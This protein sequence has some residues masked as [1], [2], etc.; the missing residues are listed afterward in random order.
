MPRLQQREAQWTYR[1]GIWDLGSMIF[2]GMALFKFG[3]FTG[4]FSRRK[5]LM[6]GLAGITIGLLLGWFRLHYQQYSLFDYGKYIS[7]HWLP[8]NIFFPFER[9]FM[10]LGYI[11]LVMFFLHAAVLKLVWRGFSNVGQLAL[12]NYLMQSIICA[13]FFTGVGMGY[14][15]RLNQ[16]QLYFFAAEICIVQIIFS[17]LWLRVFYIG[18]AEWLWRSLYYGKRLPF[19]KRKIET[20]E[21]ITPLLS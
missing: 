1:F 20:I 4:R 12:T 6:I 10:T 14:F 21:T 7:N 17:T 18:P 8:Y 11:G 5:F 16:Y 3:F 2:L 19:K 9:A 15:G 13:L